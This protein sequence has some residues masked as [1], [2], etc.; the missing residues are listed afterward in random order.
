M[1]ELGQ[2][3]ARGVREHIRQAVSDRSERPEPESERERRSGELARSR[4]QPPVLTGVGALR[5]VL[6]RMGRARRRLV[7]GENLFPVD[8]LTIPE[9][10]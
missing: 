8:F 5:G 7:R 3:I 2:R 4:W 6:A 9:V 10:I 1:V